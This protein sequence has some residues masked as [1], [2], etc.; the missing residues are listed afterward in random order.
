MVQVP[1]TFRF[2]ARESGSLKLVRLG[3]SYSC[4]V[5]FVSVAGLSNVGLRCPGQGGVVVLDFMSLLVS[6]CL[7][8]FAN[9][10]W[11]QELQTHDLKQLP[12]PNKII[13]MTGCAFSLCETQ[14]LLS[15]V[16]SRSEI[17][18]VLQL[19]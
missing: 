12:S 16:G 14:F 5:F 13:I 11:L 7:F 4:S 8:W 15:I 17:Q 2:H 9:W 1:G 19:P 6:R 10:Q 3:W 18:R